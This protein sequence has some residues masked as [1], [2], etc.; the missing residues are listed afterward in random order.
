MN[1]FVMHTDYPWNVAREK[2][3]VGSEQGAVVFLDGVLG[4]A[5]CLSHCDT[6]V[7]YN[8][9]TKRGWRRAQTTRFKS[10][11]C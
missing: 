5:G 11:E 7:A 9:V 3:I 10:E 4:I 1:I 6:S 8:M 2:D